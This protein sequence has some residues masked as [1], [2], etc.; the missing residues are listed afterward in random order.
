MDARA[1]LLD[2]HSISLYELVIRSHVD[3]QA[4]LL[5]AFATI[6]PF[7]SHYLSSTLYNRSAV[8][9][10]TFPQLNLNF[11]SE[12][13]TELTESVMFFNSEIWKMKKDQGLSLNSEIVGLSIPSN[14]DGLQISL[15][16]MHK[17]ID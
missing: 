5:D 4:G 11:E 6:C 13:W 14:L 1:G 12:K 10:D 16:R 15:T 7:F 8:E 17:L 9:A 2:P 3:A